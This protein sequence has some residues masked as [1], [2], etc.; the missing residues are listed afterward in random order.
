[1]SLDESTQKRVL[2]VLHYEH[3]GVGSVIR[4]GQKKLGIRSAVVSAHKHPFGFVADHVWP[5]RDW[6]SSPVYGGPRTWDRYTHH[7]W[8]TRNIL[9]YMDWT[10]F[11]DYQVL[12][13]HDNRRLPFYVLRHW[14][15]RIVQ[16]YHDPH[17][18]AHLYDDSVPI[19]VSLPSLIETF[20]NATWIPISVDTSVFSPWPS[21]IHDEVRIGYCAQSADPLK[22]KYIPVEEIRAAVQ[23]IGK[24]ATDFPLKKI[25]PHD[26][27]ADYYSRIDIWVDRFGCGFY[28]FASIEAAAMGVPVVT[29][30]DDCASA[31]VPDCPFVNTNRAELGK[32]LVNLVNNKSEREKLGMECREWVL[33]THDYMKIAMLCLREYGRLLDI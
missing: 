3:M 12:H 2:S 19:F 17:T 4:D 30:I 1:M 23:S 28:G 10:K 8:L 13:C 15:G 21:E 22:S 9:R 29:Q 31:L 25:I 18:K 14:K 20:P 11:F 7:R 6:I 27:M 24:K 16:H 5:K 26:Q 33:K 32:I